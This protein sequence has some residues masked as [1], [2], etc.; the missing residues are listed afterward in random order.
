MTLVTYFFLVPR[1]GLEPSR[2]S[3]PDPK[4]GVST[5]STTWAYQ[6][7]KE[8]YRLS[9]KIGDP[10]IEPFLVLELGSLRYLLLLA[11]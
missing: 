2:V 1:K 6:A 9:V 5:N 8:L 3:A 10:R 11:S 7:F 4:S